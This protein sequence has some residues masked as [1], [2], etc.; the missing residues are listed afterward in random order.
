M[1]NGV[2]FLKPVD[3]TRGS[4]KSFS[5]N[6]LADPTLWLQNMQSGLKLSTQTILCLLSIK[7]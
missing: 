7:I 4:Q 3:T 2:F 6:E 1:L 5:L